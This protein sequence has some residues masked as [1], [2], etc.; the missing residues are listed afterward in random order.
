L[1]P[2]FQYSTFLAQLGV[3]PD[4]A[5]GEYSPAPAISKNSGS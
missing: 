2:L 1:I 5:K 4:I 3:R